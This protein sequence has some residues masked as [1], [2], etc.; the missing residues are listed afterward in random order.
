MRKILVIFLIFTSISYCGLRN[1]AYNGSLYLTGM[2]NVM[3][4]TP[5]NYNNSIYKID[6]ESLSSGQNLI[7]KKIETGKTLEESFNIKY[8][9]VSSIKIYI[10][11][12]PVAAMEKYDAHKIKEFVKDDNFSVNKGNKES[13]IMYHIDDE[14]FETILSLIRNSKALKIQNFPIKEDF[15]LLIEIEYKNK[16]KLIILSTEYLKGGLLLCKVIQLN[17]TGY[18]LMTI[19]DMDTI[20][21][22][23][24]PGFL[25][26]KAFR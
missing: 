13:S 7:L 14:K 24:D 22:S 15:R 23:I 19:K 1:Q 16:E 4:D 17:E 21:N 2:G 10:I 6:K 12:V 18:F 3:I 11:N 5:N 20:I 25:I 26:F 9:D 8:H